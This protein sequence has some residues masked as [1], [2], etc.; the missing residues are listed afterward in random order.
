MN[1]RGFYIEPFT[2][3]GVLFGID[4]VVGLSGWSVNFFFGIAGLG[5]GFEEVDEG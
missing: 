1:K 5:I 3:S 4:W 2:V